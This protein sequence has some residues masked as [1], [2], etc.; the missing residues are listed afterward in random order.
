M[1][2]CTGFKIRPKDRNLNGVL[3]STSQPGWLAHVPLDLHEHFT[4]AV[5]SQTAEIAARIADA[6]VRNGPTDKTYLAALRQVGFALSDEGAP[7]PCDAP[8]CFL[9]GHRDRVVG[10]ADLFDALG[11]YDHAAYISL[12]SAGHYLPLEQPAV[13][14]SVTKSWLAQCERL[15]DAGGD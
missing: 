6:L 14:A 10:F 1:M 9:T 4:H 11:S 5:G 7:T 15:L 12:S 8:V 13:F 3:A 2:V